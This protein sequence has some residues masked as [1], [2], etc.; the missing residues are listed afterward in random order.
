MSEPRRLHCYEY[1]NVE[2]DKVKDA[3]A[4]D[5]LGLFQR[6]TGSAT[7]RARELA[8]T[9]RV[10]VGA[11][12][13][14]ADVKIEVRSVNERASALGDRKTELQIAWSAATAAGLFPS[15]EATLSI[16]PLSAHETQIEID[17]AYRPPLGAVGHALDAVV[18]HRI[19]EASV[20][21]F[22]QDIAG[23]INRELAG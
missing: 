20:L 16:Y 1:V 10:A 11:L 18:G 13:L 14:G 3:L 5:A 2:Y 8:S 12:E 4:R 6:A 22:V 19:A 17:G 7:S 21:R 23:R 9:L 15:M